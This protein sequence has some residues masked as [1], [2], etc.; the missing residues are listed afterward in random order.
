VSLWLSPAPCSVRRRRR[1][2]SVVAGLLLAFVVAACGGGDGP[3]ATSGDGGDTSAQP[4]TVAVVGRDDLTWNTE[5]LSAS[6]GTLTVE[7]TCEP[8]VNHN[9]VIEETDELVAECAPG[10]TATGTVDLDPGSYTY[11]C[12]VPGH[13][14]TMRGTLTVE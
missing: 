4:G 11:V 2:A 5:T 6:S 9:L 3:D 14:R 13:E 1:L 7:L 10:E 12:T 8:A